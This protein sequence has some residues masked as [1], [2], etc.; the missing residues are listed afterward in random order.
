MTKK[1]VKWKE[2]DVRGGG[3]SNRYRPSKVELADYFPIEL[4]FSVTLHKAQVR[5]LVA[6]FTI[7]LNV[8]NVPNS[9]IIIYSIFARARR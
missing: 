9:S 3:G 8:M 7:T 1:H 6:P 5:Y 4:G 2:T